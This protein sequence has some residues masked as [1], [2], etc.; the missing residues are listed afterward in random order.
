MVL[1]V[2]YILQ[3]RKDREMLDKQAEIA[4]QREEEALKKQ[5]DQNK[6]W[7]K[8]EEEKRGKFERGSEKRDE[9][10]N[11]SWRSE[12]PTESMAWKPSKYKPC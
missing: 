3:F 4:R 2:S 9:E 11:T 8:V 12:K 7:R 5:E 1:M 10:S 6:A